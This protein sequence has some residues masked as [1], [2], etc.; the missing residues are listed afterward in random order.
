M[1]YRRLGQ[2]GVL[3]SRIGFGCGPASGYD[4]GPIDETE[5]SA[6]VRLALDRGVNFYDVADVYGFGRAE[7]LLSK[8]LGAERHKVIVA[9]KCGLVWDSSGKVRRDLSRPAI[10]SALEASLRR[11]RLDSIPL[12]QLHWPD[13][14]IPIEEVMET[15]VRCRGEGK[16]QFIGIGNLSLDLLGRANAISRF[17]SHQSAFNLLARESARS[18]FAW[19]DSA[20]VSNIAHSSLARGLLAG[21]RFL[22]TPLTLTD[23][24]RNSPYFA[25]VGQAEKQAL[26][27]ALG[28]VGTQT[29]KSL[30]SIAL[31]WILDHPQVSSALVGIKT[32]KQAEENLE[33]TGWRLTSDTHF[34]LSRLSA[35]CPQGLTGVPA[36]AA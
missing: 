26:L 1:E 13:P 9:T 35:A 22:G 8:A 7:E 18:T 4:Y 14:A 16:A 30:S 6:A 32:K 25:D 23:T 29:G 12:Y 27:D 19:C 11:L 10:L 2:S 15:L 21:R 24:R 33:A 36:H 20:N 34:L 3:I 28:Q 17:E 31:R 5:W